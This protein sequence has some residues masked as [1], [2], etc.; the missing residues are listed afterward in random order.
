V[1][2]SLGVALILMAALAWLGWRLF[3]QDRVLEFR[4]EDLWPAVWS[5]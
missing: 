2:I 1:V 4:E 5:G 3:Q